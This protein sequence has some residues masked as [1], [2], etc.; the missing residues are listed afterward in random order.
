MFKE[1]YNINEMERALK[2]AYESGNRRAISR[3]DCQSLDISDTYFKMYL[4][5][6]E[7]CYLVVSDYVRVK[8]SPI[9]TET[10]RKKALNAI[11]PRWK[12]LLECGEESKFKRQLR[13]SD[14]DISDLDGNVG[15]IQKKGRNPLR[16]PHG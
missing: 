5:L 9:T 15:A 11:Y 8:H 2:A 6:I 10:E 16:V 14:H 4:N 7:K 12:E 13:C 3:K 1:V